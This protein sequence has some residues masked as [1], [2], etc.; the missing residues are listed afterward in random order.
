[1]ASP[2]EAL[3]KASSLGESGA[4]MLEVAVALVEGGFPVFP[5]A[6]NK[7]PLT[8]SGFKARSK[9]IGQIKRWWSAHPDA[10]PAIVPGDCELAALDVD[11]TEAAIATEA[12]GISIV[13]GL[14]VLTGGTSEPFKYKDMP[15][16]PRHVYVKSPGILKLD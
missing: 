13:F 12:A 11:S 10:M 3:R 8:P 2:T 16:A 7:Q 6:A 4:P 14:V 1:M 15:V 5:C 9:D